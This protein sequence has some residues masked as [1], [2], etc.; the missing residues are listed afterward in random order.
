M[1]KK[2]K[3][4]TNEDG[5]TSKSRRAVAAAAVVPAADEDDSLH[6][7]TD[8]GGTTIPAGVEEQEKGVESEPSTTKQ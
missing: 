1:G 2:K 6:G 3:E 5:G 4:G 8:L 7:T